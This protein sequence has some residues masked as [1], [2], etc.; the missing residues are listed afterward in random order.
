VRL[1]I[2]ECLPNTLIETLQSQG[3]DVVH[4]RQVLPS[5]PDTEVIAYATRESR[6]IVTSDRG[7]PAQ[8]SS[9]HP[10]AI[11]VCEQHALDHLIGLVS[12]D[13]EL[14]HG[15]VIIVRES[16]VRITHYW[17]AVRRNSEMDDGAT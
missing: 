2:D 5:A 6:I 16:A 14:E 12:G 10:F 8:V 1:L 3:H 9:S 4:I 15:A 11:I 13:L 17:N 7:L